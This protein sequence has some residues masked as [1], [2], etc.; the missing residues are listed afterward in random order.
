MLGSGEHAARLI[1]RWFSVGTV[2]G[3]G[4]SVD[5]GHQCP[6]CGRAETNDKREPGV[7]QTLW[8]INDD[9]SERVSWV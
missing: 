9:T 2:P 5:S 1:L 6:F 4:L 3:E 7:L 8:K